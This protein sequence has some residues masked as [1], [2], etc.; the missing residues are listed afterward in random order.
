MLTARRGAEQRANKVERTT[1]ARP[2]APK[3]LVSLIASSLL[4][5]A[6]GFGTA[7]ADTPALAVTPSTGLADGEIV[8][9]TVSG[10]TPTPLGRIFIGQCSNA[11]GNGTPLPSV[12][13]ATDCE[14]SAW[15]DGPNGTISYTAKQ[16]GI[17]SANRACI[18]APPAIAPCFIY[19]PSGIN[20]PTFP[21]PVD[22][23]FSG[24]ITGAQP[25]PTTTTLTP[26]G[27]PVAMGKTPHAQVVV[28]GGLF[29]PDGLVTVTEGALVV[30]TATLSAGVADVP[31]SALSLGTHALVAH[32]GGNG[33]FEASDSS[34]TDIEITSP[35]NITI[36]DVAIYSGIGG[37]RSMTFPIVLSHKPSANVTVNYAITPGTAVPGVDYVAGVPKP[38]LFKAGKQ[39]T[40]YV[41][42]KLLNNIHTGGS[43]T[44]S[45]T[46]SNPTGG[47]V[48]RKAIGLGTINDPAVGNPTVNIGSATSP[49]GDLGTPHA[50]RFPVTL[51]APQATAITVIVQVVP[52]T[53]TRGTGDYGG[54]FQRTVTVLPGAVSK[55]LSVPINSDIL[56]EMDEGFIVRLISA[57]SPVTLGESAFGFI[58]SDE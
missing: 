41:T 58:L 6:G 16:T 45:I 50:L 46:L 54:A 40:R 47:Y 3:I 21:A 55:P 56:S 35:D 10:I 39:Q 24:D 19:T 9:V 36:G 32:Y 12:N 53:A 1:M 30:G 44:F 37:N 49:E 25:E 29:A 57:S 5:A 51:S 38:L 18:P 48:I 8:D 43:R 42:V 7:H 11:Y 17:G 20:V 34:S 27:S 13:A 14:T 23:F 31:L 4:A 33:S 15:I 28:S 52:G 2:R 22:I 26:V